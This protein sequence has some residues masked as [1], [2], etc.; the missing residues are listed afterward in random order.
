MLQEKQVKRLHK[1]YTEALRYMDNAKE[2]LQKANKEDDF[3]HD[4]KYVRTACGTAYKNVF[5]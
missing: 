3:Y 2:T 1:S 5:S 4:R